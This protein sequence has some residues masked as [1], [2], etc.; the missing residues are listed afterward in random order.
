MGRVVQQLPLHSAVGYV[1]PD[2]YEQAYWEHL[3][4]AP[5]TA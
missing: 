5:Q 1:P 2:E 3:K 4:E